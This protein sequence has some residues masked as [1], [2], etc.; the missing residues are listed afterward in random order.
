MIGRLF[1]RL[2]GGKK[3][4]GKSFLRR[5]F[6]FERLV[7]LGVLT[8]CLAAFIADPYPVQFVR[9]KTFDMFQRWKPREI[10]PVEKK[11]VVIIDLDE[12]S[13]SEVG[14]WP[15]SRPVLAQLVQ[16]LFQLGATV[17]AFDVVFPESD[18]MNP[19]NVVN[20]VYG[21]DDDLRQRL[22][23]MPKD[24]NDAV[25]AKLIKGKRVILGQAGYWEELEEKAGPPVRK[26][27]ALKGPK[28]HRFLPNFKAMVRNVPIVEKAAVGHGIFT[29]VPEPDG[30]VRRVPTLFV[31]DEQLYPSLAVEMLRVATGRRTILVETDELGI[32]AVRVTKNLGIPTDNKGRAWPYFSKS[33]RDKYV[34]AVEVLAG[35]AD[36]S[37]IKGR[38]ALIGTSAVG[39]LDIRSTPIDPVFPGVEVHAQ[40]IESVAYNEF[41]SRPAYITGAEILLVFFGGLLMVW[42]VPAVGAR[43][44]LMI[45]AVIASSA[46]YT[47]WHLFSQ[48]RILFDAFFAVL[49]IL[50]LY[51]ALTYT[52]YAREEAERKQVRDA[53]GFYLA[54]AMVE[55]LAEDPSQL[56]LGGEKRDMTMLFCDVRGFTTISEQFDAEG[57]TQLINK[58][59]TPLTDLI[60]KRQGTVDKYMGDCIM[61]FWNAPLD[62]PDHAKN[63]CLAALAMN[64][65]MGPLNDR[66]EAEAIADGRTH[67]PLKIGTGLNSGEVVVGNMG[68]E[69]RFDYSILGDQVNLASRLEGQCKTYAVD[70]VIGENTYARA[71]GLA[72]LELDLIKVK[73]KT[74]AVRIHTLLGD[75]NVKEGNA[76]IA[77]S[78]LHDEM[79]DAYRGQRWDEAMDKLTGCR[80]VTD[81]FNLG[82]FYDIYAERIEEY[83]A[84]PPGE[85]WD[86]VYVATS[87]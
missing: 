8:A 6:S 37:I 75:E 10:L 87:K 38:M 22:L 17:V 27:V 9:L 50:A 34:P 41:L 63:A 1:A 36:A 21:L 55:K 85:G 43:W 67:I 32:Q 64:E 40:L 24:G 42:L 30:I 47:S 60:M 78:G 39:M 84:D 81:G 20:S 69:Q 73:G 58:L 11:P 54:P 72:A 77:L 79:L 16:N 86:G 29:V 14:Q 44:T 52:G 59:L 23:K 2:G 5:M 61:A 56:A 33:D 70:I 82:G 62:D 49:A 15:W 83:K 28:P 25:F 53:F 12:R 7:G 45:F 4:G 3:S 68:S 51:V 35:T 65:E 66:L 74:E 71:P 76:F 80:E 26:S 46:A 57:L 13:L 48:E 19:G 31:Y 18:R